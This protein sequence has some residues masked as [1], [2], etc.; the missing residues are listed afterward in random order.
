MANIV[1]CQFVVFTFMF[2]L[3]LLINKSEKQS[4]KNSTVIKTRAKKT[5]KNIKKKKVK[6]YIKYMKKKQNNKSR[7]L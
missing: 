1:D 2:N 3:F 6:T 4:I 7:I 5:L